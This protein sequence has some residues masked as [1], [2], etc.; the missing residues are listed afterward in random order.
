MALRANWLCSAFFFHRDLPRFAF[1][2]HWA[3]TFVT[4][5]QCHWSFVLTA[6]PTEGQN[7]TKCYFRFSF[8]GRE[9]GWLT[10]SASI[11]R[12]GPSSPRHTL[13][14]PRLTPHQRVQVVRRPFPAGYCLPPTAE[15]RK[16]ERG[17]P[18]LE[19]RPDYFSITPNGVIPSDNSRFSTSARKPGRLMV[20]PSRELR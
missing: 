2:G 18:D 16:S 19:E 17:G 11:P 8:D 15:L 13:P 4:R 20:L 1:T 7:A 14:A 9:R 10:K 6:H 3:Y 12:P 5:S